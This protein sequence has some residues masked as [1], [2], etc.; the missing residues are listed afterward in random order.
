MLSFIVLQS[1]FNLSVCKRRI[2]KFLTNSLFYEEFYLS[3]YSAAAAAAAE[4]IIK[5]NL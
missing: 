2:I 5:Y 1:F 4:L 3:G